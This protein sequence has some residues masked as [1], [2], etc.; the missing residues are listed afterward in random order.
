MKKLRNV[1]KDYY[2]ISVCSGVFLETRSNEIGYQ[3][4]STNL[5][6]DFTAIVPITPDLYDKLQVDFK[7]KGHSKQ[8]FFID[9]QSYILKKIVNDIKE[10]FQTEE[11]SVDFYGGF[12]VAD[13]VQLERFLLLRYNVMESEPVLMFVVRG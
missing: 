2:E 5:A 7:E 10:K 11:K 6:D 13:D 8:K 3:E 4:V 9:T 1:I 12:V